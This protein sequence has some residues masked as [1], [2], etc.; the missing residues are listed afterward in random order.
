MLNFLSVAI[1]EVP[2]SV[3]GKPSGKYKNLLPS[4]HEVAV[5]TAPPTHTQFLT[6]QSLILLNIFE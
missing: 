4:L 2:D 6:E 5:V 1:W 3:Y